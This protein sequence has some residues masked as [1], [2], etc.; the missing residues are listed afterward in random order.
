[1]YFVQ[2]GQGGPVKIGF[3]T[4]PRFRLHALQTGNP[5]KLILHGSVAGSRVLERALHWHF[6]DDRIRGEWFRPTRPILALAECLGVSATLVAEHGPLP[7]M[8]G[9]GSA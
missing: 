6:R 3:S 9:K 4:A 7:A 1:M 8:S 2:A 5:F